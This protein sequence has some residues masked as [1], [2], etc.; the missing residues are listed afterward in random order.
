MFNAQAYGV[1]TQHMKA[2]EGN[3]FSYF[4]PFFQTFF[5]FTTRDHSR[6]TKKSVK[7]LHLSTLRK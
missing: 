2:M 3:T 5:L 4:L 7:V 6:D 1:L